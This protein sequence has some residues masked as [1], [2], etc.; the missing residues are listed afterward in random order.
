MRLPVS[1]SGGEALILQL[2]CLWGGKL[3][4]SKAMLGY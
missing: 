2:A 3:Q 1:K 4:S